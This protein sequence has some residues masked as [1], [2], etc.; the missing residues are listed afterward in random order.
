MNAS[1]NVRA[2]MQHMRKCSTIVYLEYM[3]CSSRVRV[4]IAIL[5]DQNAEGM[6]SHPAFR[7]TV[8][9]NEDKRTSRSSLR[10]NTDRFAS[11]QQ[12]RVY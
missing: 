4:R 3:L 11:N 1:T 8:A 10:Y 2:A 6:P 9:S 7:H 5:A 12:A